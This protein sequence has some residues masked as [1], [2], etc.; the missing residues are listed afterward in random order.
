[1]SGLPTAI[2][3]MRL[4]ALAALVAICWAC[5]G[6]QAAAFD[7]P[8]Q[9]AVF[10]VHHPDG[11][12]DTYLD[13]AVA[14]SYSGMLPGAIV[15]IAVTGPSGALSIGKDDF[16]YHPRW[17]LFRHV[18]PGRPEAGRYAF[19]VT[20]SDASG[21]SADTQSI[22][23]TIPIPDSSKFAP[24]DGASDGCRAPHFSWPA[25]RDSGGRPLYYQ[26]QIRDADRRQVYR[27][28]YVEDML[29]V[30][31]PPDQL[32]AGRTY[33]WR[34]R[35]ADGPDWI[36]LN[37]RSH[38]P[39]V[40]LTKDSNTR[41][42]VYRYAIPVDTGDGWPVA[43]MTEEGVDPEAIAALIRKIQDGGIPD[44][45]SL[46]IVKNGKLV[47]EE[48]FHGHARNQAH[49]LASVSKS[50]TSI[51]IGI[52]R[53]QGKIA[54]VDQKLTDYFPAYR[55]G[56]LKN[57]RLEHVLTM[58]AG[59]DWNDWQYPDNDPRDSTFAM[60]QSPDWIQ[61]VLERRAVEVPG[62]RF[63]Y[64]NGLSLLLGEIVKSATGL[65]ADRYARR[66]LFAPLGIS[67]FRWRKAPGGIVETAGGLSL[68]PR[69]MAKIGQ[70]MLQQGKW[71]GK[72][73]LSSA[74][75]ATSTR[76]HIEDD[77]L[78]AAG[79]GYQWWRGRTGIGS[80]DIEVFYAA[81]R[82]GQYI[83]VCP[84]LEMVT[85]V[86]SKTDND[87]MGEF[88]PQIMM[89]ND[90][91]PA[92]LSSSPVRPTIGLD[93]KNLEAFVGDFHSQRLQ[94]PLKIF[95]EGNNL[96]FKSPADDKGK[97]SPLSETRFYGIS[98]EAGRFTARFC[99][100]KSG[101]VTQIWVQVGFGNWV[102][103]KVLNSF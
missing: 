23:T 27:S 34:V 19:N 74:W 31:I 24:A 79:Y 78:L 65:D 83:F 48:Y 93:E 85:V 12:H 67:D 103:D 7:I 86:T 18:R 13:V 20:G 5:M 49:A 58:T 30:R 68:R 59:L 102:F 75:V 73:V 70:M 47:L 41:P 80:G 51:L 40:T 81:G 28:E 9:G 8:V 39:W 1:M 91:I 45:H 17:R 82:G 89:V 25:V 97:L 16:Q 52:A 101:A 33:Q 64:N 10:H 63:V 4:A 71:N 57:I 3:R 84:E 35:V 44:I 69:D 56:P 11:R 53:D 26:L 14:E 99:R 77:I 38:S 21:S 50:I 15:T 90:I 6:W 42:C 87:S 72:T 61:F 29:S 54:G 88:R 46:L 32:Q 2:A 22:V 36:S 37:N 94:L 76:A 55:D 96:F 98:E 43:A 100:D 95:R 66:Y 92:M 60:T 62:Q